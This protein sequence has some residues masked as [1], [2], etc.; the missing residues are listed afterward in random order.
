MFFE[1]QVDTE[2]DRLTILALDCF[3]TPSQDRNSEPSYDVIKDGRVYKTPLDISST[4]YS[5]SSSLMLK[6][7]HVLIERCWTL[8]RLCANK[9]KL[10]DQLK[11]GN[12][13]G[14]ESK[15]NACG[16][17]YLTYAFVSPVAGETIA[18]NGVC[19]RGLFDQ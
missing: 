11:N 13:I 1:V 15:A 8:E 10:I 3:A 4:V 7:C 18:G 5:F 19:F 17:R 14:S 2:D 6:K 9:S 16:P 12:L